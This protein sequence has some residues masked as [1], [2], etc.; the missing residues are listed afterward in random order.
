MAIGLLFVQH[1][2]QIRMLVEHI[3]GQ[4]AFDPSIYN[5]Y[6]IPTYTDAI[7]ISWIVGGALFIAVSA[8]VLPAMRAARLR[9]VEALRYE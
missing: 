8:S 1:I 4:P 6:Q 7:T 2:N 9:P 3:T 5:F